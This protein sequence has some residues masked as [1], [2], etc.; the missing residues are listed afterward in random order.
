M[1][2]RDVGEV[3]IGLEEAAQN[4]SS[5]GK[6]GRKEELLIQQKSELVE[7]LH[8]QSERQKLPF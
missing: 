5:Q 4:E 1:P 3:L 7:L 6:N 2:S 8:I